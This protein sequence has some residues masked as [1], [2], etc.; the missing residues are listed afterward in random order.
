MFKH[1]S[2]TRQAHPVSQLNLAFKQGYA[3]AAYTGCKHA[4]KQ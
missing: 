3:A 1:A 4:F 2:S